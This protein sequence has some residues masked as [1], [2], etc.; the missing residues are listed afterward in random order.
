MVCQDKG[1][2]FALRFFLLALPFF[3]PSFD[4]FFPR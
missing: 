2:I 3:F 1:M 4:P